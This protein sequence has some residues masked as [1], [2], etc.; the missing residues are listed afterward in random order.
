MAPL[1]FYLW[2]GPPLHPP[3]FQ[4]SLFL[5]TCPSSASVALILLAPQPIISFIH[6]FSADFSVSLPHLSICTSFPPQ[7][8]SVFALT[9]LVVIKKD[10]VCHLL[11]S[12]K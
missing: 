9:Y 12:V 5:D 4:R 8:V 3:C 6:V 7:P 2:V 10:P 1:P 11:V